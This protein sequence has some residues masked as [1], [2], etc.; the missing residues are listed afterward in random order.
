MLSSIEKALFPRFPK[1]V[2]RVLDDLLGADSCLY[3]SIQHSMHQVFAVL[4]NL[5]HA[6][7][8]KFLSVGLTKYLK[9][10]FAREG[11]LLW[12]HVV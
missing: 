9:A 6:A 10:R 11:I 12:E 8:V 2:P 7:E 3:I 1:L 4:G 5:L